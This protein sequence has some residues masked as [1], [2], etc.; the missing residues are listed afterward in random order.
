MRLCAPGQRLASRSRS[1]GQRLASRSRSK[2]EQAQHLNRR[3]GT[4]LGRTGAKLRS[5][6]AAAALRGGSPRARRGGPTA[7][8]PARSLSPSPPPPPCRRG[9]QVRTAPPRCPGCRVLAPI[10]KPASGPA[11]GPRSSGDSAARRHRPRRGCRLPLRIGPRQAPGDASHP[12]QAQAT[13]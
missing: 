3:T 6:G 8:P 13:T 12:Q 9:A 7:R 2:L 4:K 11:S 10:E 1:A 5:S